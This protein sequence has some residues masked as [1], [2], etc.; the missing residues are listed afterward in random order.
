MHHILKGVGDLSIACRGNMPFKRLRSGNNWAMWNSFINT[1]ESPTTTQGDIVFVE[2]D[3]CVR[4]LLVFDGS[5][6]PL[7]AARQQR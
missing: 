3:D 6:L 2:Q 4:V 1:I 7:V 5:N